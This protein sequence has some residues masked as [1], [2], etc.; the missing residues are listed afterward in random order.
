LHLIGLARCILQQRGL[1][2]PGLT[3]D[4]QHATLPHPRAGSQ[5]RDPLLFGFAADQH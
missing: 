2:D 4:G 5:R 3:R 1:P